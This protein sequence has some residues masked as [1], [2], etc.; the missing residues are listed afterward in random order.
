M[1]SLFGII[2]NEFRKRV[3]EETFMEKLDQERLEEREYGLTINNDDNTSVYSMNERI[4][5]AKEFLS[6]DNMSAA[7][8]LFQRN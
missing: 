6:I 7:D 1:G 5:L 8:A 2:N 3:W 4:V